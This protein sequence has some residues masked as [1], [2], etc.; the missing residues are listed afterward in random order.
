LQPA[1]GQ[2]E[3]YVMC[4]CNDSF[5]HATLCKRGLCYHKDVRCLSV[6]L[7]VTLVHCVKTAKSVVM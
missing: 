2:Q 1:V 5:C 3:V 4:Q 7:P 6:R